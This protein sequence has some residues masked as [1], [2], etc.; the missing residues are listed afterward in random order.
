M[1][2]RVASMQDAA[3]REHK[4]SILT[5]TIHN[6]VKSRQTRTIWL[7][8]NESGLLDAYSLLYGPPNGGE[9]P[10]T[11]TNNPIVNRFVQFHQ[12]M[13]RTMCVFRRSTV[14]RI[15][16][17]SQKTRPVRVLM[18]YLLKR[19]P[20]FRRLPDV[21]R[22]SHFIGNFKKRLT[23]VRLHV[24]RCQKLGASNGTILT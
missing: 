8:D 23:E 20:L 2:R 4:P 24:E 15:A 10:A 3:D 12:A 11:T 6:L 14:H 17:L 22:N 1:T 5:E 13:L 19:E 18:D 9:G 7:I 16:W 21:T